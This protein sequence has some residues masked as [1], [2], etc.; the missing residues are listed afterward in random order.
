MQKTQAVWS[1]NRGIP[2]KQ[3]G[4]WEIFDEEMFIQT[5][6]TLLQICY[7]VILHYQIIIQNNV[8]TDDNVNK[9]PAKLSLHLP[10]NACLLRD[11]RVLE[12]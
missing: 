8:G 11:W 12:G 7:K 4:I 2:F 10:Q 6:P 1:N 3:K 9:N 5:P